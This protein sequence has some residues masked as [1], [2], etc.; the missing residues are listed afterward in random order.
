MSYNYQKMS[1]IL[2]G[3]SNFDSRTQHSHHIM[4]NDQD[5]KKTNM[6]KYLG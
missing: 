6:L 2:I 1:Y 3:G 4:C 5:I